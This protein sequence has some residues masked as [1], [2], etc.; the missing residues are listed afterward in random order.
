MSS[1]WL[2]CPHL[3]E[4]RPVPVL[5]GGCPDILYFSLHEGLNLV[6]VLGIPVVIL[7]D[8]A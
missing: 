2:N 4:T 3:F 8:P 6:L 1:A 7:R 5:G